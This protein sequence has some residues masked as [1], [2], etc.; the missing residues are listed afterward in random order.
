MKIKKLIILIGI[1][2]LLFGGAVAFMVVSLKPVS[3]TTSE[4]TFEVAPNTSKIDI[5]KNL[6]SAGLIKN[7]FAALV[8]VFFN[9]NLNL[10]AGSY[11]INKANST[12]DIIKQIAEGRIIDIVPTVEVTF[13]EGKRLV[14]YANLISNN[15]GIE[16]NE[17]IE[18]CADKEF[19]QDLIEDYWFIDESILNEDIYYPL[20]GYLAPDTYEFYQNSS[21]EQIIIKMLNNLDKKLTPLKADI[22]KSG[23]SVHEILTIASIAEKEAINENDRK[24]VSQVIYKRLELDMA[25][26]MDVTSYYG[27]KKDMKEVITYVDLIDE[28]PYNTRNKDFKGLPVGS[29]CNPSLESIKAAIY[30][31][32]TEYV[33]FI[34]DINTGKVFFFNTYEEFKNKKSDLGL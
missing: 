15:F 20:E 6:K 24:K 28:N 10:Q 31:S 18:K 32:D 21:S 30:P 26:G 5:V 3:K 33:Y 7:E 16:Y 13:V 4:V 14:D 8:Y 1:V 29:I 25:L 22:E 11:K 2:L 19:L 23:K 12:Q 17:F 27:V 9:A 34:A